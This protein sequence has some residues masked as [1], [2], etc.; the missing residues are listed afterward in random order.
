MLKNNKGITLIALIITIVVLIIMAAVGIKA[1]QG[2]RV[3]DKTEEILYDYEDIQI[4]EKI[5]LEYMKQKEIGDIETLEGKNELLYKI[6]GN[7]WCKL[8]TLSDDGQYISIE[9]KR[10]RLY[11][12]YLSD[13][14]VTTMKDGDEIYVDTQKC[15]INANPT[16]HT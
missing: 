7:D 2:N 13:G 11:K 1:A 3:I 6:T 4:A 8:A 10:G 16:A 12:L 14:R 5:R 15:T 9:S